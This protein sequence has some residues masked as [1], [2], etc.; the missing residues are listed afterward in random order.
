MKIK[1]FRNLY[2]ITFFKPQQVKNFK[3][4]E[5]KKNKNT[6]KFQQPRRYKHV[7]QNTK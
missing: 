7:K 3:E 2:D 6:N 4:G 5:D 1:K